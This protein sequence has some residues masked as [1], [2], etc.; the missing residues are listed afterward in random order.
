MTDPDQVPRGVLFDIDGTLVDSNYLHVAA[1]IEA[2]QS[3]GRNV[4]AWKIHRAIGMDSSLMLDELLGDDADE[5]GD[6]AKNRHGEVY[7]SSAPE[8]RALPGARDLIT[9]LAGRGVRVVLA[10]SAPEDELKLL[11]DVLDVDDF[12]HAVTSAEDVD[13]AKPDP[14]IVDIARE[15]SGCASDRLI[16]V[17]DATW[18]MK[19]A[20]R[21]GLEAVGVLTGGISADE[22]TG[23]GAKTVCEGAA[24]VADWLSRD[25]R[26]R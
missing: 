4:P 5:L 16:F 9:G 26:F 21:A 23:A 8:L 14:G 3:V 12:I 25:P 10:T 11:R 7:S 24:E 13:Q 1:W 20:G 19:A 17:G 22:L 2:F 15:R 18:D 6:R